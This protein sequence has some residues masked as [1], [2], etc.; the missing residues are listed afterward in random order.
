MWDTAKLTSMP[1]KRMK[2]CMIQE[3]NCFLK[4]Q[5]KSYPNSYPISTLF[6]EDFLVNHS[7]SQEQDGDLT[8]FVE[9]CFSRLQELLPL[10]DLSFYSLRTSKD[11]LVMTKARRLKQSSLHWMDWGMMSHGRCLTAKILKFPNPEIVCTLSD[12]LEKSVAEKYFLLRRQVQKLLYKG[13]FTQGVRV[14]S[15]DGTSITLTSEAGG[16]GGKTGLYLIEGNGLPIISKTKD[17]YQ[18]AFPGDSID[19][20]FAE[21]NSRRDRVGSQ[22]AHTLTTSSTQACY[23]VDMN[24]D[25]KFTEIARCITTRQ[26]SGIGTHKGEHSGVFVEEIQPLDMDDP[27][28]FALI[29]FDENGDYHIGRIR[30]LTP[31]ECWRLQGF[32]DWQF[33]KVAA[34]G[35]SDSKLY[36]MAGNAVTVDVVMAV[37]RVIKNIW[38]RDVS[39]NGLPN[40]QNSDRTLCG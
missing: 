20:A 38:E 5:E 18:I 36:R 19:T 6:A 32:K 33:D 31:R 2:R 7:L 8:T 15:A 26:D 40:Q 17:G 12:V 37:G 22:I 24:P 13:N 23:C 25:P 30:K 21:Q 39:K 10:K 9:H 3:V 29:F 1:D 14:Y 16:V 4:M 35:M 34:T 11:F 27:E 28:K